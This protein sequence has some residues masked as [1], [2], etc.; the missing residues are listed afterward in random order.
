MNI[1]NKMSIPKYLQHRLLALN[2]K[3]IKD[4]MLYDPI[5]LYKLMKINDPS[6]S[7]NVLLDLYAISNQ[8]DYNSINSELKKLLINRYKQ[9]L[10]IREYPSNNDINY[11]LNQALS[12]AQEG[13][14]NNE[15]PIGAIIVSNGQIIASSYNITSNNILHHAEIIAI[16]EAQQKLNSNR[17]IDCDIYVTIEP[18]VMC[19]GA[20]IQA[21]IRNVIFGAVE[22]KTGAIQSQFKLLKNIHKINFYNS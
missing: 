11:Y 17:L 18:C 15:V 6:L 3:T 19:V 13:L 9:L 10:P 1:L 12:K 4:L 20:I 5:H 2:I 8:I 16:S 7:F 22:P 21:R 14:L